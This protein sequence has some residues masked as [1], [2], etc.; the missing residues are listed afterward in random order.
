M[1]QV[2]M[3]DAEVKELALMMAVNCVRNTCVEKYHSAGKLNDD[4]MKAFNKEVV[5]RIY[6]FLDVLFNASEEDRLAFLEKMKTQV[7]PASSPLAWDEPQVD[8]SLWS[9]S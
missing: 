6:T 2:V 5:N 3:K 8:N 1:R 4:E 7:I 9:H